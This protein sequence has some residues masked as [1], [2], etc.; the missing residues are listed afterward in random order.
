[1]KTLKE[2]LVGIAVTRIEGSSDIPIS[3]ITSDSRQ[4]L[5]GTLFVAIKGTSVDGH[6]FIPQVIAQGAT[7][8][9]CE[10]VPDVPA[11]TTT[12][13]CVPNSREALAQM[14]CAFYDHPSKEL[15]L[16]GITGTNGKTTTA[17]LLFDL[18]GHLGYYCGLLSTVVNKI[19]KEELPATH[20]TPDPVTLNQ[21]LRRMVDAGCTHAFMEVSSHALHQSRVAGINFSLAVFSNITRDHLDYHGSFQNYI[22][23]KKILFDGLSPQ[24]SAL[25]NQDDA[26]AVIMVQ[27]CGAAVRTYA[28]KSHADYMARILETGFDGMLMQIGQQ[29]VWT[30]LIGKF[31]AYN[32]LCAY[33]SADLL[34]EEPSE[35]LKALSVLVPVKGRFEYLRAPNGLTAVVDY[36]HTP[37]ALEKILDAIREIRH[38]GQQL[39]AVVGCGGDRDKGK[40][41]E[42]GRIAALKADKIVLTS[43]NPRSED[44]AQIIADIQQGVPVA[45]R[46]KVLSIT[47]RREAIRA[48]VMLA[49][50]HDIVLV[51]GKGHETYQIIGDKTLYFS[52]TE[53]LNNHFNAHKV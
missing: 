31:N 14:A 43:D 1:M 9:L 37:D 3:R 53:E 32:L 26:H 4:A 28:L 25:I 11:D 16:T 13:V 41:P 30:R 10:S 8:I 29:E 51:A 22:A 44:P 2:L 48:A 39:I 46:R 45:Q 21:L 15:K 38:D 19:G 17:T 7:A 34:G 49:Q 6:G 40:R 50:P 52:D 12:L 42:M 5:S 20:T 36:A 33:A 24:A 35:I 18:F 47:D 23:A 27:N